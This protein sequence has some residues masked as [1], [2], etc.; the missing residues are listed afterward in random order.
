[1]SEDELYEIINGKFV[2]TTTNSLTSTFK[3][4]NYNEVNEGQY[5]YMFIELVD[6]SIEFKDTITDTKTVKFKSES[7]FS[8][9][10]FIWPE[11]CKLIR[12]I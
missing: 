12:Y 7:E 5:Y 2:P 10:V 3:I 8:G 1:M 6:W 4:P 9:Y 11:N